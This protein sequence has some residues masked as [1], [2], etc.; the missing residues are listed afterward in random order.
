MPSTGFMLFVNRFCRGQLLRRSPATSH[1][2]G[3]QP[4]EVFPEHLIPSK[5]PECGRFFA[6]A[7]MRTIPERG[8][9]LTR[10]YGAYANRNRSALSQNALTACLATCSETAT[11]Q[12]S[13]T[14]TSSRAHWAR[15]IRKVFE[16]DPLATYATIPAS[17]CRPN[18][19][20]AEWEMEAGIHR[21]ADQPMC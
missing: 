14:S 8:Q 19:P 17:Y 13:T 15:L 2:S 18:H 7:R 9:H 12:S 4:F 21:R 11:N 1:F 6:A 5:Q 3:G 10:Y 16:V 20:L